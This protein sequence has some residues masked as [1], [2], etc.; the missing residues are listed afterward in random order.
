MWIPVFLFFLFLF[1]LILLVFPNLLRYSKQEIAWQKYDQAY[2]E[3]R[4][5]KN[6]G[7]NQDADYERV[8]MLRDHWRDL[9]GLAPMPPKKETPK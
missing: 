6:T 1:L 2:S 4:G 3:W 9:V 5:L 8:I 7:K